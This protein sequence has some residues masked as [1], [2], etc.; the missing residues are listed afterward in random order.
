MQSWDIFA[1]LAGMLG[2]HYG[3]LYECNFTKPLN[4]LRNVIFDKVNVMKT[5]RNATAAASDPTRKRQ[6][7]ILTRLEALFRV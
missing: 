7:G 6:E 5:V 2:I 4:L 3:I 1:R